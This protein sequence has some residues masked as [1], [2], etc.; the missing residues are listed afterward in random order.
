V[1]R[2]GAVGRL[3]PA[4]VAARA[5]PYSDPTLHSQ[6]STSRANCLP[7]T[8]TYSHTPAH[9][10]SPAPHLHTNTADLFHRRR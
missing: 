6:V 1:L 4:K 7:H 5:H 10:V 3:V 8:C 2:D 9:T